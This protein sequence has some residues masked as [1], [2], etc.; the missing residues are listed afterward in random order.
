MYLVS[1][2][3]PGHSQAIICLQ[4]KVTGLISSLFDFSLFDIVL[5]QAVCFCQQNSYNAYI[6]VLHCV[7]FLCVDDD[8]WMTSV[9]DFKTM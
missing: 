7:L 9:E 8:L 6:M 2:K 5:S 3:A 1:L 4:P